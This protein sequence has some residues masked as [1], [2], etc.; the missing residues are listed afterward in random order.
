MKIK[1]SRKDERLYKWSDEYDEKN[2]ALI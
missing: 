2:E 1:T